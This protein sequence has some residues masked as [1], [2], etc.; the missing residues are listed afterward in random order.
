MR[1]AAAEAQKRA[2]LD[3]AKFAKR[4]KAFATLQ[5]EDAAR[6]QKAWTDAFKKGL[7]ENLGR[8]AMNQALLRIDPL[9]GEGDEPGLNVEQAITMANRIA[10]LSPPGVEKWKT[11]LGIEASGGLS[12]NAATAITLAQQDKLFDNDSYNITASE[13]MLV[14]IPLIPPRAL[15]AWMAATG[16]DRST[17]ILTL[18]GRDG[19]WNED[20]EFQDEGFGTALA[21]AKERQAE[22]LKEQ[23]EK[24]KQE[25]EAER[26]RRRNKG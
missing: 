1:V 7:D 24:E 5:R 21:E 25:R 20:N 10:T 2:A 23:Q 3:R 11:A 16:T 8:P 18:L 9:W 14:R 6:L 13:S 26:E 15:A 22:K 19:V 12:A 17:A 4:T